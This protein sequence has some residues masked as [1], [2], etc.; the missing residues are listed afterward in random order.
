MPYKFTGKLYLVF[1]LIILCLVL[2]LRGI[3]LYLMF[4]IGLILAMLLGLGMQIIRTGKMF[5]KKGLIISIIVI[6]LCY[7]LGYLFIHYNRLPGIT[8]C[9]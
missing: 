4:V 8:I 6:S 2:F 1:V 3:V 5:S 7:V 9:D